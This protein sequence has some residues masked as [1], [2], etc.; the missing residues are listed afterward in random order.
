[1]KMFFIK[2]A[3]CSYLILAAIKSDA[4]VVSNYSTN[5]RKTPEL[6]IR[7]GVSLSLHHNGFRA[8]IDVK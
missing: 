8:F 3:W 5:S 4:L 2:S 1:M 6:P 7:Q